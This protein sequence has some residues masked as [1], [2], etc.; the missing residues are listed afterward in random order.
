MVGAAD[1]LNPLGPFSLAMTD[2]EYTGT[3]FG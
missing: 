1:V 2:Q 3:H